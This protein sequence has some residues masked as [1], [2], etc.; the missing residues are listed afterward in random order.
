[1]LPISGSGLGAKVQLV[2][3]Q[4]SSKVIWLPEP[5]LGGEVGPE[6]P[7]IRG[8]YGCD[9]KQTV[10]LNMLFGPTLGLGTTDHSLPS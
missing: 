9:P 10:R 2:P 1:M 5:P 8:R 6:R 4:C 7:D 3:S